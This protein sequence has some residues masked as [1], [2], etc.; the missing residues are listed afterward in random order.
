MSSPTV[1][2]RK[3]EV[4]QQNSQENTWWKNSIFSKISSLEILHHGP[5]LFG[6]YRWKNIS[7]KIS[8]VIPPCLNN[9]LWPFGIERMS[10]LVNSFGLSQPVGVAPPWLRHWSRSFI[11]NALHGAPFWTLQPS[12]NS[13][14]SRYLSYI[15][16]HSGDFLRQTDESRISPAL[17]SGQP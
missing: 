14:P 2:F 5:Y 7:F 8:G 17:L 16:S 12:H 3:H 4:F 9:D 10:F 15:M 6:S 11:A 13:F 1:T